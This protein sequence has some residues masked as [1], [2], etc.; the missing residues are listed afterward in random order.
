MRGSLVVGLIA[1]SSSPA[2]VAR[3]TPEPV[4]ITA[5]P[6]APLPAATR[7]VPGTPV[8]M[9]VEAG[10]SHR[11]RVELAAGNALV[12]TVVQTGIDVEVITYDSIGKQLAAFDSPNGTD[13]PEPFVIEAG[14]AGSYDF[15]VRPFVTPP[16][17]GAPP[18][19]VA[20]GKY[21]ARAEI[22]TADAYEEKRA[23]ERF[24]STRVRALWTAVRTHRRDAVEAFW[25][26]LAGKSPIVEPYPGAPNDALVTFVY[27]SPSPY[28]GLVGADGFREKPMV[29]VG[30]S[31][32]WTISMRMP[33]D[34]R[35]AYAFI[36]T[37]G[38][39]DYHHPYRPGMQMD[40]RWM[41]LKTDPNNPVQHFNMSRAELPRAAPQPWI[42]VKP[43]VA[44]GT[45]TKLA[46]ASK[47][48][49]EERKLGV[50]TPAG[51]DPKKR[52][53][54]LIV[55][56]G[57]TYG[58]EPN[59][60]LPL[61]TI[62]DNLI[63]AKKIPPII[64]VLVANQGTRARDLPGSATFSAF[65][66]T[67]LVPKLRAEFR[68]GLT[69]AETIVTGSSFGGLC[70]VY[71]AFHHPNVIGNVLSQS[72]SLQYR[73]GEIDREVSS[74]VE[75]GW[76]TR[77]YAKSK[78]LPIRFYVDVGLFE[79]NLLASNRQFRDVLVAKGYPLTYAELSG[80]HDYWMWRH[81]IAD[82]LI[83]LLTR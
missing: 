46:I 1:C 3:P 34:A 67:E 54:L 35:F 39:D 41:G 75:G 63:A 62:L 66:A 20:V 45:I 81:T 37:S 16:E 42:A 30:D 23:S 18:A 77:D 47:L 70:S 83:A 10:E 59:G 26:D 13:G 80:G 22:L 61:P 44:K 19:P 71:T 43:D 9:S 60:N 55:F 27:R 78:K 53:P 5:P 2:P 58:L 49:K 8:A 76:L 25:R 74:F 72:A 56:D 6:P 31:D 65:L 29:R 14:L 51:H 79:D 15:E 38:P 4:A 32:L 11:Y 50:Y 48:L 82:G 36:A 52:Y 69:P 7:F 12:G 73:V 24:A 57:E 40:P 33:G 28:V 21:E 64:A 17:P 68:A